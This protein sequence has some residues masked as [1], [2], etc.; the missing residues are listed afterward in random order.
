MQGWKRKTKIMVPA[1]PASRASVVGLALAVVMLAGCAVNL[2][3][4]TSTATGPA[5][6]PGTAGE[7][8]A[9]PAR[10]VKA[11]VALLLPITANGH[12][13][14]IATA[15]KQAAE[16]AVFESNNAGFQLV[17]KDTRGT[18]DG[19]SAAATAALSEGAELILGP[20]TSGAAKSVKPVAAKANVGVIAFS[21][22]ATAAS[23]GVHV[24][25]F[26]VQQEVDRIIGYAARQ[27]RRS[28]AALIADDTYGKV[29]E[30]AFRRAVAQNGGTIVALEH[31]PVNAVRLLEPTQKLIEAIKLS[32]ASGQMID[33][34]FLPGGPATLPNLAPLLAHAEMDTNRIKLLGTG[35]WDQTG[36]AQNKAFLGGW[37]PA[38]DPRGWQ[39]FSRRFVEAYGMSPPRIATLAYDAVI[40]ASK[41]ADTPREQ[42]STT[43]GILRPQGFAGIDG[44]VRFTGSG[45][46]ER[47]LA[48]MEVQP[49]GAR[50]IEPP[51][52]G[53]GSAPIAS[54]ANG[55]N[56]LN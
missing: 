10:H 17:V 29:T 51:A 40:I 16:L 4:P 5:L 11:K 35:G 41:L 39:D 15:M 20:L 45:L 23:P 36:L 50:M 25:G 27:G 43:A 32:E 34:I 54:R 55:L 12:T 9:R 13:A 28:F 19:A 53:F 26:L 33:A 2:P 21:N 38:P 49:G 6:Q 42:R 8:S 3:S 48:I 46:S 52:S 44:P 14:A 7:K 1:A 24:V 31:Y 18:P 47:Q 56:G 37:F 22:D 30:A